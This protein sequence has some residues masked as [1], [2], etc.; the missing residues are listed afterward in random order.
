[1]TSDDSSDRS[2]TRCPPRAP[3]ARRCCSVGPDEPSDAAAETPHAAGLLAEKACAES[4]NGFEPRSPPLLAP[5]PAAPSSRLEP[6]LDDATADDAT[7]ACHA[8]R[9]YASAKLLSLIHI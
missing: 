1:M 7:L 2:D 3:A 4:A 9:E 5:A 6:T 8:A